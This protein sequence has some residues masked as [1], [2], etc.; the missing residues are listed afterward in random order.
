MRYHAGVAVPTGR[1]A[2]AALAMIDPP[3]SG[4]VMVKRIRV[5]NDAAT[6]SGVGLVRTLTAG[7]VSASQAFQAGNPPVG[8]HG[9]VLAHTWSAQPTIAGTPLWLRNEL[10][11]AV[12]GAGLEWVFDDGD[13]YSQDGA[14]TQLLLVNVA[15]TAAGAMRV[16]VTIDA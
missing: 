12:A 1:A 6:A 14:T 10:I 4:L 16:S 3:A 11:P 9:T 13:L 15:G 5:L 2:N 8:A 7:T